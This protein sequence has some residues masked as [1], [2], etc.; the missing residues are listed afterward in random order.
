MAKTVTNGVS[1]DASANS[2]KHWMMTAKVNF[3]TFVIVKPVSGT[4]NPFQ[5]QEQQICIS[6]LQSF[7]SKLA[8]F[9][10]LLFIGN[11]QSNIDVP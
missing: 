2:F 9:F 8:F 5:G 11:E 1:T 7:S 3:Y 10:G 6:L 4:L